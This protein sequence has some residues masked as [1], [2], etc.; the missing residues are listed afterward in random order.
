MMKNKQ[1]IALYLSLFF[2]I[3]VSIL[4]VYNSTDNIFAII[5]SICA[6]LIPGLYS[7]IPLFE[8][9]RLRKNMAKN[10]L[11]ENTFTDRE[12]DI[13]HILNKLSITEHI[14]EICGDG[15]TCG[16][17]WIAKRIVDLINHP[18]DFK[19]IKNN[20][21]YKRAYYIDCEHNSKQ[22]LED[23]FESTIITSKVVII[24]DNVVD[25]NYLISKQA[26][27]HF[28][29]IYI[30][31]E[32]NDNYFFKYNVSKFDEGNVN[33]LQNKIKG[34]FPGIEDITENEIH[35][36]YKITNGN[37][38]KIHSILSKQTSVQ[39]IKDIASYN[40]T[41]YDN[42][43]DGIEL[44][45]FTGAYEDAE[46]E[47]QKFVLSNEKFFSENDDLYYKY[48]LINADCQHLLNNYE[49]ALSLLSI[50]ERPPYCHNNHRNELEIKKAHYFKHLWKCND[51][52]TVLF[53][54]KRTSFTAK[55]DSLGILLAKYFINDLYVPYSQNTSLEE[56]CKTYLDVQNCQV[57]LHDS[58]DVL[59]HKRNGAIYDYY[60]NKPKNAAKLLEKATEVIDIYQSQNNRLLANAYFIR[61]ELNRVYGNYEASI[62]DYSHCLAVTNDNNIVIQ[63]QLIV[64]YLTKCKNLT[65]DFE[66]LSQN[67]IIELC[68]H[69]KYATIVYHKINSIILK[70]KGSEELIKQ[71][72]KR[73]MPIL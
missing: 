14:I 30:L 67:S 63:T 61:G 15:H 34:N 2:L 17:S 56:F 4:S 9:F 65:L 55:V 46:K 13:K 50:I 32:P 8:D 27:Y 1:L 58:Q 18:K 68:R 40:R 38:G 22:M 44:L 72:D 42:Q 5:A 52:L 37:I 53:R 35:I 73:I 41:E 54:I 28:Q 51:A 24:F 26:I 57:E 60:T 3:I 33:E 19:N 7:A 20:L 6:I 48:M 10:R 62:H 47:L 71:F 25:L 59:K 23:F 64:Y 66:L 12:E 21:P 70:D 31:K 11:S 29:L 43:L 36:L 45:L 39:W 16:K 49:K 69:N